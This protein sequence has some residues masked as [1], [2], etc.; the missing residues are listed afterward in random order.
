MVNTP[1]TPSEVEQHHA[2][3]L[4]GLRLFQRE[5]RAWVVQDVPAQ[6]A[7]TRELVRVDVA[8][9]LLH[10]DEVV[11]VDAGAFDVL[12]FYHLVSSLLGPSTLIHDLAFLHC[13]MDE[14]TSTFSSLHSC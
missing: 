10:A 2:D 14:P 3:E 12:P 13:M 11:D 7:V 5:P 4:A 8:T 9:V 6:S 1:Q